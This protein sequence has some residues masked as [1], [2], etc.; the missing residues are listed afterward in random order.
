MWPHMCAVCIMHEYVFGCVYVRCSTRHG[1]CGGCIHL[2]LFAASSSARPSRPAPPSPPS[3]RCP[4]LH[5]RAYARERERE[6]ERE[7]KR[8]RERE[9]ERDRQTER[10]R[11]REKERATHTDSQTHT[12]TQEED[13]AIPTIAPPVNQVYDKEDQGV[14]GGGG[15]KKGVDPSNLPY[16]HRN[17]AI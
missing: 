2:G 15:K 10:E 7:T 13:V 14:A 5:A 9:R 6:R 17:P 8:E 16:L 3:A 12:R 4:S 1:R 11:R